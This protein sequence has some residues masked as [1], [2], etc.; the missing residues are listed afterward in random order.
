MLKRMRASD[1]GKLQTYLESR[2]EDIDSD[3]I[4]RVSAILQDVKTRRDDAVREY[5]QQFD[6]IL[7][8]SMRVEPS[9]IDAAAAK[10]DPFFVE[11]MKKAKANIEYYHNA[12]KQNGYLLQKEL[13]IY[14]GQRALP[15]DSVGIYVPGG[16]A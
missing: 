7:L 3:I 9:D 2:T 5:T 1:T 12:Q 4:V 10:A 15:L 13:G 14:L 8:D 6:G 16:R 11:S